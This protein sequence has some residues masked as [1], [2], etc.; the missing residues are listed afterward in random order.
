MEGESNNI[1]D[2][3]LMNGV[4]DKHNGQ[5]TKSD[6]GNNMFVI[7]RRYAIEYFSRIQDNEEIDFY[8][9]SRKSWKF[10]LRATDTI[11][12]NLCESKN[13]TNE[14]CNTFMIDVMK[15]VEGLPM[16]LALHHDAIDVDAALT[17]ALLFRKQIG[18]TKTKRENE[19]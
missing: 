19:V 8:D 13:G 7:T 12:F 15:N 17:P 18:W 4:M 9:R 1:S 10:S 6:V 11:V 16:N 3:R 2:S 5:Y 14:N